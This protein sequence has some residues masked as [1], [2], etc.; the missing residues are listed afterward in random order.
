MK[1]TTVNL[2]KRANALNGK[3]KQKSNYRRIQRFFAEFTLPEDWAT[4]LIRHLLPVKSDFILAM[5]RTQWSLG[6]VS[7]NLLTVGI[8]YR[9]MAFPICF[10][11][12][13]KKGHSS[14]QER[15]DLMERV[16]QHIE[17]CE[18]RALVADREFMGREWFQWLTENNM[19][20]VIRLKENAILET[21]QK[22]IPLKKRFANL[23]LNQQTT[24][25]N[26]Q[27]DAQRNG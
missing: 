16:G 24:L 6:K 1:V 25:P 26:R 15:I 11:M 12:L 9:D 17:P 5:D 2:T 22:A 23:T 14:T 13:T 20:F 4:S 19:P 10:K 3:V 18:I 27:S 7:I 8:L 21:G